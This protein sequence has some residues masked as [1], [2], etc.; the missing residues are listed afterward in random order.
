ME[1]EELKQKLKENVNQLID[2]GR[3]PF[4]GIKFKVGLDDCEVDAKGNKLG[5]LF[6]ETLGVEKTEVQGLIEEI[7][8]PATTEFN[9][10]LTAL[11]VERI[12]EKFIKG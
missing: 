8:R 9:K 3:I 5:F 1:K 10:K 4:L 7:V 6:L 2:G 12:Y 11:I